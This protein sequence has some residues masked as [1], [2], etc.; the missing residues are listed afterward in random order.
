MSL[1]IEMK[2]SWEC[3]LKSMCSEVARLTVESCASKYNFDVSEA[4][5]SL[6]LFVG[7][8]VEKKVVEKKLKSDF[9][10][11]FSKEHDVLL[12][13]GLRHN[14]GLYTQCQVA[15]K[16]E[17]EFCKSCLALASKS[18]LGKPEYG[19][20]EDRLA[21][22]IFEYVDPQ[23]RKPTCYTKVMKKYKLS[24]SQVK[25]EAEKLN[26]TVDEGHFVSSE[27]VRRGRPKSEKKE[28]NVEKKE[29]GRP[30]KSKKVVEIE[31]E[32]DDLFASLVASAADVDSEA[33]SVIEVVE[34]VEVVDVS[35][36]QKAAKLEKVSEKESKE[37]KAAKLAAEKEEKAAKLAAEKEEKAAKLA[38]EKEEKAAKLVAEKE[39]KAAKLVAEK[40]EKAAKLVAAKE[41]KVAAEKAAKLAAKEE[42][43]IKEKKTK[44][45]I[46]EE[47]EEEEVE[48]YKP[49]SYEGNKQ[50]YVRS[51]KSGIV[52]DRKALE[53]DETQVIIGMWNEEKQQIIF[54]KKEEEE[55]EEYDESSDE[56][57]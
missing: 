33:E 5:S 23:G 6:S 54:N 34:V 56:E 17:E 39:E 37:E 27:D 19:R 35:K 42:K 31:G 47:E 18:E 57:E 51:L 1:K 7:E 14:S 32:G 12:C 52:Y 26:R 10:L 38:A 9:P 15:R 41:E 11:P 24:E 43:P 40:E 29:K 25:A 22:G 30:K 2:S 20:I 45:P 53:K 44:A 13:C 50:L 48:H 16:G 28:K 3:S 55:E 21:C 36:T 8:K 49:I 46:V 4:L